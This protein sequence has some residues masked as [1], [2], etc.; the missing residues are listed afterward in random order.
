MC[1]TSALVPVDHAVLAATLRMLCLPQ[2]AA[3]DSAQTAESQTN[4]AAVL[5]CPQTHTPTL[6]RPELAQKRALSIGSVTRGCMQLCPT[7][8]LV[9]AAHV[10][11]A[12][13][14]CKR[15]RA[16]CTIDTSKRHLLDMSAAMTA[17][18]PTQHKCRGQTAAACQVP[19]YHYT[20]LDTQRL[21]KR[22]CSDI[23]KHFN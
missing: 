10:V 11:L 20:T 9:S 17:W 5:C 15:Q 8:A 12:A 7:F 23:T 3:K 16:E 18:Q 22:L 2:Q 19:T 6:P 13:T 14:G 21:M 1:L 4:T